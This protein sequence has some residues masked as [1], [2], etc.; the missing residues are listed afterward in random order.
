MCGLEGR[1]G[2]RKGWQPEEEDGSRE[3]MR[4]QDRVSESGVE[5]RTFS[6]RHSTAKWTTK[7]W[8]S[9]LTPQK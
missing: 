5:R 9:N 2:A 8:T 3:A 7:S 1:R 4:T 6:S